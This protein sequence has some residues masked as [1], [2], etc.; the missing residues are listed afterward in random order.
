MRH[1]KAIMRR[2]IMWFTPWRKFI[3]LIIYFRLVQLLSC[4]SANLPAFHLSAWSSCLPS[5]SNSKVSLLAACLLTSLTTY[6]PHLLYTFSGIFSCLTDCLT[7]CLASCLTSCLTAHPAVCLPIIS[8]ETRVFVPDIFLPYLG[9]R[10]AFNASYQ[11][12]IYWWYYDHYSAKWFYER[13][14]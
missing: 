8:L 5:S 4:S 9:S 1:W 6:T 13:S 7:A 10:S 12:S 14:Y 2:S 11:H 3:S